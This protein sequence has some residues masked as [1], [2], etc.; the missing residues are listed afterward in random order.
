MKYIHQCLFSPPIPTL[1]RAIEND[2]LKSFPHIRR[3]CVMDLELDWLA[4]VTK[5]VAVVFA[6][7]LVLTVVLRAFKYAIK[8]GEE[9]ED[10]IE[11]GGRSRPFIHGDGRR[12]HSNRRGLDEAEEGVECVCDAIGV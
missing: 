3:D 11:G 2:Q 1:L 10:M 12:I 8:G 9:E 5:Y 4:T 6:N 7:L